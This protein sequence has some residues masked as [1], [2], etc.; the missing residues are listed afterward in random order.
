MNPRIDGAL[1]TAPQLE[2]EK[3]GRRINKRQV[4]R[5]ASVLIVVLAWY[6]LTGPLEIVAQMKFPS[7]GQSWEAF[8]QIVSTGYAGASLAQHVLHSCKLVLLGFSAAVL[9]GVPFGMLIGISKRAEALFNPIFLLIRPIPP[10]AWIPLAIVWLGLGD[11]AKIMVIWMA[12]FVPAVINS[13]AGVRTIEP[14]LIEAGQMLGVSRIAFVREILLPASLPM[15]FTG[16]RLSLQAS[17][18]TLVAGE[19]IGAMAGLGQVLTQASLDIYPAMILVAM[20]TVALCGGLMTMVLALIERKMMPWR[21][22]A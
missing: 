18:T 22:K 14:Y 19:L 7:P 16:L 20:I 12:A 13:H 9:L 6:L 15:L 11:A 3:R 8:S 5:V 17:W 2:I 21:K 1:L 10:L 4:T